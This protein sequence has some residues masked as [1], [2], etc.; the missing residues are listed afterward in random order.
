M[1]PK[2]HQ[3][4]SLDFYWINFLT[5]SQQRFTQG[6]SLNVSKEFENP[7]PQVPG[8]LR[9]SWLG[10]PVLLPSEG[11][12]AP[13]KWLLQ[14]KLVATQNWVRNIP[15]FKCLFWYETVVYTL[16]DILAHNPWRKQTCSVM[17]YSLRHCNGQS[18]DRGFDRAMGWWMFCSWVPFPT[19]MLYLQFL[20]SEE[21]PK[22]P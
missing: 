20:F 15:P 14:D 17:G 6:H 9:F 21:F 13:I 18:F 3:D 11:M 1:F 7:L 22:C 4:R 16:R 2:H 12:P 10:T 5:Q 8:A 19:E